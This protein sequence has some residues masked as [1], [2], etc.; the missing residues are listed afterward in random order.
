MPQH[1]YPRLKKISIR[2]N[3]ATCGD[4][5]EGVFDR[6]FLDGVGVVAVEIFGGLSVVGM[7]GIGLGR[8]QFIEARD[9]A[10]VFRRSGAFAAD[11]SR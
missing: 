6:Q 1:V 5:A 2:H 10:T 9:A 3:T 8:E 4:A 11:V 7:E